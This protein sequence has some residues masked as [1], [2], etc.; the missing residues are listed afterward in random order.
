VLS[1]GKLSGIEYVNGFISPKGTFMKQLTYSML[2][3][4]AMALAGCEII[5]GIFKAG[6]WTGILLVVI[7]V[8]LIIWLI[9][10]ARR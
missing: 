4:M 9:S 7:V 6:V 5:G 2:A 1:E 8:A 3:F 10:R